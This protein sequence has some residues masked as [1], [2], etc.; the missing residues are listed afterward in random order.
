[1]GK[2]KIPSVGDVFDELIS[3]LDDGECLRMKGKTKEGKIKAV[4]CREGD[5]INFETKVEEE[6]IKGR[7]SREGASINFET[8]G[9]VDT[10][11]DL[12]E[13]TK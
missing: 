7:L 5:N 6:E 1:M 11:V 9:S 4:F 10:D 13:F 3:G 12:E 2:R 8:E